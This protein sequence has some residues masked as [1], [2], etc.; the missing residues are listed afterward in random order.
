M[1]YAFAPTH[2]NTLK[3]LTL[4]A[5]NFQMDRCGNRSDLS[6]PQILQLLMLGLHIIMVKNG[7]LI[8]FNNFSQLLI[9]HLSCHILVFFSCCHHAATLP[10]NLVAAKGTLQS[11]GTSLKSKISPTAATRSRNS[12]G[13][14]QPWNCGMSS[15]NPASHQLAWACAMGYSLC[16]LQKG[17][18][19]LSQHYT[20]LPPSHDAD[21]VDN[22]DRLGLP[23]WQVDQKR[24]C[25][26]LQIQHQVAAPRATNE[27]LAALHV[28]ALCARAHRSS[29][30]N[31]FPFRV[32]VVP[33]KVKPRLWYQLMQH[34]VVGSQRQQQI[35]N[36]SKNHEFN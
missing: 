2:Y 1:A 7:G 17:W 21:L 32:V 10:R 18:Q 23:W 4:W 36:S 22:D 35:H 3:G 13:Y 20:R 15:W 12:S 33:W 24:S 16:A 5:C 6:I 19:V 27:P 8:C 26:A 25:I 11:F 28:L 29:L 9:F 31:S 14:K 34:D 30:Q